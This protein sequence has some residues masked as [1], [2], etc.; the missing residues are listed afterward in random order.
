[1]ARHRGRGPA[2]VVLVRRS[3]RRARLFN[4]G[5]ARRSRMRVRCTRLVVI[6]QQGAVG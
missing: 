1:M 4:V 2:V 5:D 6:L 3:P